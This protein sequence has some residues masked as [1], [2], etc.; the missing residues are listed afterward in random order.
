MQILQSLEPI[1]AGLIPGDVALAADD[2]G[3]IYESAFERRV[4]DKFEPVT[5][6]S[7]FR[8][9]SRTKALPSSLPCSLLKRLDRPRATDGRSIAVDQECERWKGPSAKFV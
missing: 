7:V 2:H 6:D 5:L 4:V 8:I 1:E 9:A 3:V